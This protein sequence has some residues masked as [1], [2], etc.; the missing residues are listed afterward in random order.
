MRVFGSA[1]MTV[2]LL[3]C[4]GMLA[5]GQDVG[6][7]TTATTASTSVGNHIASGDDSE[8]DNYRIG[9][10]DILDIQVFHHSDL[11]QRVSVGPAGTIVL[12]RV[13]HPIT[14]VCKTERELS[15]EIADAYK[16]K[17]LKDP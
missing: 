11:N 17:Y 2:G 4:C 1:F 12:Y 7:N 16:E 14:A 6:T 3:L 9:F 5:S 15:K 10:Q 8:A 13:D